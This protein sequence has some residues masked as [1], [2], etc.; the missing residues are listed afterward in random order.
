[1]RRLVAIAAV[2]S[3]LLSGCSIASDKR[4][5]GHVHNV[6]D[7]TLPESQFVNGRMIQFMQTF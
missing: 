1:M 2:C 4:K 6:T 3:L 5:V 7:P